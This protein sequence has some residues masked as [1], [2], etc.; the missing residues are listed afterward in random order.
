MTAA[1]L[2]MGATLAGGGLVAESAHAAPFTV[3]TLNDAGPGSLRQ[4]IL[5]ANAAPG[6]DQILFASGLS[7]QITLASSL[8]QITTALDIQGPGAGTLAV[9]GNSNVRILEIALTPGVPVSISGLSL[10]NGNAQAQPGG[11][12]V[13]AGGDVSISDSVIS[14]ST[15]ASGGGIFFGGFTTGTSLT[16][17]R[18]TIS[19]NTAT[20]GN[21]GG[22]QARIQALDSTSGGTAFVQQSTISGN[23]APSGNGGGISAEA[24][25]SGSLYCLVPGPITCYAYGFREA[26]ATLDVTVRGSTVA[27][28]S[29]GPV[30]GGIFASG[31]G[32][33]PS[34]M[35]SE[36]SRVKLEDTIAADNTTA[37]VGGS[38]AGAS[39][40]AGF[41]LIEA[42]GPAV[43]QDPPGSNILGLDPQLAPLAANGGPTPTQAVSK[44]SPAIDKGKSYGATT[45]QRGLARPVERADVPN[46]AAAGADGSDIG[47]FELAADEC[48]GVAVTREGTDGRDKLTGTPKRDVIA[49]LGGNDLIRGLGGN[50][51]VCGGAGK[52]KEVGGKGKDELL[53]QTG[54]DTLLGS[55]GNDKL[56]GGAG[57]DKIL[58]GAGKDKL[59]GQGGVDTLIGGAGRDK[60]LGGAGKDVQKQ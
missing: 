51:L 39:F 11:A 44:S 47:A 49:G 21:G 29:G 8:P 58:G 3:N 38:N 15:A 5:D 36:V 31:I 35:T 60:L 26:H 12:V 23:H 25:A 30:S 59:L 24:A 32:N 52:D 46:S 43:Q 27:G 1:G 34:S 17:Q 28:N 45:D 14:G 18:S 54:V 9:S 41:S 20:T 16:V 13:A 42:G 56:L 22:I 19:G 7:G 53:G 33:P 6:G 40:S 10:V 37:D 57:R 55:A 48:S 4:A 2:A 50:D